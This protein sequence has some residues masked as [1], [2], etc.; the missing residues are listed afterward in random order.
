M[1]AYSALSTTRHELL[2]KVEFL[3]A[4]PDFFSWCGAIGI[5]ISIFGLLFILIVGT[6]SF[7]PLDGLTAT[8]VAIAMMACVFHRFGNKFFVVL[9]VDLFE[10]VLTMLRSGTAANRG[11]KRA[12]RPTSLL[13]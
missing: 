5:Q 13:L 8:L 9:Y 4:M 10:E 11:E 3:L 1:Q 12:K 2:S 7:D 6:F